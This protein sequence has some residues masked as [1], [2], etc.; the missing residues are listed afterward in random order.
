MKARARIRDAAEDVVT[1]RAARLQT[2]GF[3]AATAAGLAADFRVDLHAMLEL[4]ERGC[5]PRLAARILA[6]LD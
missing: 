1:W 2:A 3:D 5:P 6:P 4:I